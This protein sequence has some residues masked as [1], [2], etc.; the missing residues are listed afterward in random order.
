MQII[1]RNTD[2]LYDLINQLLDF[3]K[4][5]S[6]IRKLHMEA[7]DINA[8]I[9]N[10]LIRFRPAMEQNGL[11]IDLQLPEQHISAIIDKEAITKVCSN[12]FTNT[13]KYAKSYVN[14][15]LSQND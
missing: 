11:K 7:T 5:E 6:N 10:T 3:R 9:S 1:K 12:L 2:R 14:I 13:I 15:S 8:L 4:T